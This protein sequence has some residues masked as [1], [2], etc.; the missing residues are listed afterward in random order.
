MSQESPWQQA[1]R[2]SL[3]ILPGYVLLGIAFA[4]LMIEAGF[5]GGWAIVSCI[6]VYAG[7][8]QFALVS[9]M[10]SGVSLWM[11]ALMTLLINARMLFYGLSFL[12]L[13]RRMGW[14]AF[15]AVFALSDETF[16]LFLGMQASTLHYP[17]ETYLK[18]AL[19]NHLYWVLGTAAGVV[20]GSSIS[21]PTAGIDFSMTA[22]FVVIVLNQWRQTRQLAPVLIGGV[23]ALVWLFLVEPQ[24]F[25]LPSLA[26]T[27][28]WLVIRY[29][30]SQLV[31]RR[32]L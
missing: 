8:M 20:I 19:L 31:E 17:E 23:S 9:L 16:S 25:L 28:I 2:V 30:R 24:Y 15:Y 32:E 10:A 4:L 5:S 22:L 3:P 27:V 11:I 13:F 1:F 21:L 14:K 12:E 29:E 7:S 26:C 18:V 6:V